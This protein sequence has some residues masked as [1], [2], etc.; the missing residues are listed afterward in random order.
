VTALEELRSGPLGRGGRTI[1]YSAWGP[2]PVGLIR[3]YIDVM[4]IRVGRG[5]GSL[6][7]ATNIEPPEED[8]YE[9]IA[10]LSIQRLRRAMS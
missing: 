4:N 9:R 2:S 1:R 10:R 8:D 6:V 7:L 5:V 3:T